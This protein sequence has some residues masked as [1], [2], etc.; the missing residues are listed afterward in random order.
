[1]TTEKLRKIEK[2][3]KPILEDHPQTREDDFLLYAELIH[4][5]NPDLLNL[6]AEEF[7]VCHSELN[8][9]NIKTVE[10]IRRR[11]QAK[12]PELATERARRKRAE[13]QAVYISYAKDKT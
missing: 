11:L 5:Y 10:R 4:R 9:P 7:L 6:S 2:V 8:V 3:I 13:A 12:H 1:M